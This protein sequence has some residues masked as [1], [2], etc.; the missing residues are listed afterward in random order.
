MKRRL[1]H[2]VSTALTIP[3]QSIQ[4]A[5]WPFLLQHNPNCI[6]EPHWVM[7]RIR[8]Q[9]EHVAFVDTY[10]AELLSGGKGVVHDLEE[11]GAFMLVE[12]FGGLVDVVIC[13]LIGAADDH[14]SHVIVVDAVVVDWG[15]EHVGVFCDPF[16]NIQ[17]WPYQSS[18]CRVCEVASQW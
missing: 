5:L 13:A 15:F 9:E 7:W 18:L 14:D 12:P 3:P 17:R 6:L 8:W 1:M 2:F 4:A 10:I 16:W 11:H